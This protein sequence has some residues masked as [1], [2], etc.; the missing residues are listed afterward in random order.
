[1]S[2]SQI[3]MCPPLD[4][5]A[6]TIGE[7]AARH[8]AIRKFPLPLDI[9]INHR[10]RI[11]VRQEKA[12]RTYRYNPSEE[13]I[14]TYFNI[15]AEDL[16]P[17]DSKKRLTLEY[18]SSLSLDVY[19]TV[20]SP[21]TYRDLFESNILRVLNHIQYLLALPLEELPLHL[22]EPSPM[23]DLISWRFDLPRETPISTSFYFR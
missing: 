23:S 18:K 19:S 3:V 11:V 4:P 13:E 6:T 16:H 5:N 21:N 17:M 2:I 1:M 8:Q 22:D 14:T 10:F 20:A 15:G 12:I 9:L 7:E